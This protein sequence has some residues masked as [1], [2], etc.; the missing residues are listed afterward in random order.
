MP[1]SLRAVGD[2]AVSRRWLAFAAAAATTLA[3]ASSTSAALAKKDSDEWVTICHRT[4]STMNPYVAITV[5]ESAVDGENGKGEGQGDHF[6]THTGPVWEPGMPNGGDW[7]DIIPPVDGAHDGL[8]WDARGQA[9]WAA[10]CHADAEPPSD[11]TQPDE[12]GD[13]I[14]D[15]TDPDADPDGDGD[16]NATDP[17]NDGDGIPDDQEPDLDGD[18]DPDSSDP[19]DDGDGIPDSVDPDDD[20]DGTPEDPRDPD[21]DGDGIPNSTDRDDDG[22]GVPD[23]RDPDSN[24][25]GLIETE[26]QRITDPTVPARIKPG[27]ETTFG[28]RNDVT[29]LGKQ[30][31]YRATCSELRSTRA[32]PRGDIDSGGK[33]P[34]CVITQKGDQVTVRVV[35]TD[36]VKIRVVASSGAVAT[37]KGY[38]KV[39][40][41]KT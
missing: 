15:S 22:D 28:S 25:D 37:Y 30:V 27:K 10:G 34:L 29:D 39:Y 20:N 16:P 13:G 1:Y 3:A 36:R 14:P 11:S 7:G 8:N 6:G 9:I 26:E 31:T 23:E 4:N 24:G 41:Y 2:R 18:G 17:D 38:R 5:K 40:V 33:S 21:T 32:A 12:D 19:D 35:S